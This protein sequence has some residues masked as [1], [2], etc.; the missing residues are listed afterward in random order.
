MAGPW[1]AI[2]PQAGDGPAAY[3][4]GVSTGPLA[5]IVVAAT[6]TGTSLELGVSFRPAVVAEPD[7]RAALDRLVASLQ[8]LT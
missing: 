6:F 8:Q 7:A 1:G 5:P 4:R 2:A 3:R